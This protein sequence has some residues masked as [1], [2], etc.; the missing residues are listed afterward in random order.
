SHPVGEGDR[1][2]WFSSPGFDFGQAEIWPALV[3]GAQLHI[4][5]DQVRL[6]PEGLAGWLVENGI[7]V[8]CLPTPVGEELLGR[9]WPEGTALRLMCL[10]GEQLNGRPG[11]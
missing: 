6:D 5:P 9:C 11:P 7:T 1:L 10:G 8:V 4:V 2:A 3:H